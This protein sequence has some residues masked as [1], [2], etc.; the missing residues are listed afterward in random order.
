MLGPINI[1]WLYTQRRGDRGAG[2]TKAEWKPCGGCNYSQWLEYED[3]NG[4]EVEDWICCNEKSLFYTESV[5]HMRGCI[6]RV[7]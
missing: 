4:N 7:K 2:M 1:I 5:M 6:D 3:D